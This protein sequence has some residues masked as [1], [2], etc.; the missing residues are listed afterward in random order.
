VRFLGTLMTAFFWQAFMLREH[1]WHRRDFTAKM[2]VMRVEKEPMRLEN[3]F[4][5]VGAQVFRTG[6]CVVLPAKWT[7]A[8]QLD[9]ILE[10]QPEYV[11]GYASNVLGVLREAD[12]RGVKLP[13]LRELRSFG[14]AVSQDMRDYVRTRWQIPFSDTYSARETGYLALQC[15]GH[16][17]YH[18][19]SESALVEVIGDDGTPCRTGEVGRVVITPLHN[20][21]MPLLRYDIGDY[22]EVAP[23]CAC[24]RRL[25]VLRRIQ[26]RMR[27]TLRMPDGGRRWPTI[28]TQT[29]LDIA[30]IRR[31]KVVQKTLQDIE[32]RLIVERP[33]STAEIDNLRAHL[34]GQFGHPFNWRFV[35]LDE[36]PPQPGD[37]FEDF[38]SEVA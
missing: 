11:L 12:H 16:D 37:K 8:R 19:Q 13:W 15:P 32:V 30:P 38:V 4:G 6:P 2:L 33:L 31:F 29:L 9:R 36:F 23:D 22:A 20:F 35:F 10:E 25:P 7:F 3:W 17:V 28:G 21:G 27:N 26:G 18:V 14:E 34:T 5:D 1:L 24:G